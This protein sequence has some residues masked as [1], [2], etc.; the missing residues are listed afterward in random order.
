MTGCKGKVNF[1]MVFFKTSCLWTFKISS[2]LHALA[3]L[4]Y[5]PKLSRVMGL[6]VSA[7][8]LHTFFIKMF[9]INIKWP[10]FYYSG[11]VAS[12]SPA[13]ADKGK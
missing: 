4:D 10:N 8:F 1:F 5:L 6:V 12:S 2:L 7:D 3:V 9:L 11:S 13:L